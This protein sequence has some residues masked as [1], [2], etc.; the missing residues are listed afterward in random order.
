MY[1]HYIAPYSPFYPLSPT[2]PPSHWCQ[3]SP[4]GRICST[5]LFSDFVGEK[6]RKD[7]TKQHDILARDKCSYMGHFLVIFPCV[8]LF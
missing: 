6:K 7:T 3:F 2:T 4:L 5:I 1:T 8:Y